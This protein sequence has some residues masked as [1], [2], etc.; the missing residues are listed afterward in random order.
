MAASR[1]RVAA[2]RQAAADAQFLKRAKSFIK[3][4]RS[5]AGIPVRQP[6][7]ATPPF[8]ATPIN[9]WGTWTVTA[10]TST[11]A[12]GLIPVVWE[13]ALIGAWA[14]GTSP[15]SSNPAVGTVNAAFGS[16]NGLT[17][18]TA[19]GGAY[20]T[21]DV[22]YPEGDYIDNTASPPVTYSSGA[23]AFPDGQL[24][25]ITGV[26]VW[27][28][29]NSIESS[30]ANAQQ[31]LVNLARYSWI[32]DG[33]PVAGFQNQLPGQQF[34]LNTT[35]LAAAAP[36][37]VVNQRSPDGGVIDGNQLGCGV[38]ILPGQRSWFAGR[39]FGSTMVSHTRTFCFRLVGYSIPVK[40]DDG[41]I[42]ATLTD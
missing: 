29:E 35:T 3:L 16:S 22:Y 34:A 13:P 31:P 1:R 18:A 8:R 33:K 20:T 30:S 6:A 19:A 21:P 23:P 41:T 24:G 12:T 38:Q 4:L 2:A 36:G 26:H 28:M 14:A 25:I 15:G 39:V 7:H 37:T 9:A 40:T 17:N 42:Y 32:V 10:A 5:Q 11:V 27:C